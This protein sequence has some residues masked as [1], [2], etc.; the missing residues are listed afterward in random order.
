[1]KFQQL[2]QQVL[3]PVVLV[4]TSGGYGSGVV[5]GVNASEGYSL[6]LTSKHVVGS[7]DNG[8]KE[9]KV[10]VY[11]EDRNYP[12]QLVLKSKE[13][14]LALLRID[15]VHPYPAKLANVMLDVFQPVIRVGASVL[16]EPYPVYGHVSKYNTATVYHSATCYFGDSGGG[17]FTKLATLDENGKEIGQDYYLIGQTTLIAGANHICGGYNAQAIAWFLQTGG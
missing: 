17:L 13:Y 2:K 9:F 8:F 11:P 16:Q 6:I 15:M 14:D 3:Y 5:V 4:T 12:A 10:T 7:R 1:M